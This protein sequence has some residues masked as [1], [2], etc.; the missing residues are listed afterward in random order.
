MAILTFS[1]LNITPETQDFGIKYNTQISTTTLS[2]IAQTVELPGARWKG[3]MSFRDMTLADSATLKAFLLEL[4]G[5]SG[6]FFYGDISHT[7]PFSSVTGTLGIEANSTARLMRVTYDAPGTAR[8]AEGDY[9]QVGEDDD[10][11]LKM[12]V[13]EFAVSGYTYDVQVEPMVRRTDYVGKN[14]VYTN[15]KGV[16]LLD[17]DEQAHWGIRSKALLSDLS[18]SFLEA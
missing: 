13:G 4:R 17:S 9:V 16:F 8:L 5:A 6:R 14:L 1:A 18:L 7:S 15:P 3:S 2:G 11:E 10:R 12:V